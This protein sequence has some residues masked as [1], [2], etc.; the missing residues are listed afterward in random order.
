LKKIPTSEIL[1]IKEKSFEEAWKYGGELLDDGSTYDLRRIEQ[2]PLGARRTRLNDL[3][4]KMR[5]RLL[6]L[7]FDEVI[8]E[9]IFPEADIMKQWG[10]TGLPYSTDATIS[11]LCLGPTSV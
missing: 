8:N 9:T 2:P 7:G 1:R 10:P 5:Q 4:E 11:L 3:I 6:E